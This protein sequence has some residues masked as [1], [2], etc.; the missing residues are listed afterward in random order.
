MVFCL[1]ISNH[2]SHFRFGS[3][4]Q[5]YGL[6]SRRAFN[7]S[8]HVWHCERASCCQGVFDD[9][10]GKE[11][12]EASLCLA[13]PS[14]TKAFSLYSQFVRFFVSTTHSFLGAYLDGAVYDPSNAS[15][16]FGFLEV[17][18]TYS[19]KHY[20]YIQIEHALCQGFAA[21][22]TQPMSSCD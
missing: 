17:K 9:P 11:C 21:R 4:P 5:R 8:Y 2:I 1:T 3:F 18:F 20:N 14:N 15:Q 13:L 16:A 10:S 12:A 7:S 19:A 6:F 22:S